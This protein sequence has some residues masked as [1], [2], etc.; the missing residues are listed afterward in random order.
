MSHYF[1]EDPNLKDD[2]R[3]IKFTIFERSFSF[4]SNSGVFSK[5]ELDFGSRLLIE[6]IIKM[7]LFGKVLDLGCGIGVIGLVLASFFPH[8][9]FVMSDINNRAVKV[10]EMNKNRLSLKN[11]TVLQSDIFSNI[12]DKFDFIITN[13]PIRAGKKVVYTIFEKAYDHLNDQGV[14]MIVIRKE[15]GAPSALKK[16]ETIYPNCSIIKRKK[17]YY[18]IKCQK[19]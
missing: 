5:N 11:T 17:R 14:L 19:A 16:L 7:G 18:I 10:T 2:F 3:E 6:E 15:Q 8:A 12:N 9:H 13:P 4:I 1:I